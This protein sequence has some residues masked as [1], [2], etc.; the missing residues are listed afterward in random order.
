MKWTWKRI[1]PPVMTLVL[2]IT[3][4]SLTLSAQEEK[5]VD[6]LSFFKLDGATA[7]LKKDAIQFT[8]TKDK[9]T[10]Q[11]DHVLAASGFSLK[12]NAVND[13]EKKLED[14][15]VLLTDS[16]NEDTA[17]RLTFA[18]MNRDSISARCNDDKRTYVTTG[19][20]Y[21]ENDKDFNFQFNESTNSFVDG[22]GNYTI[23]INNSLSGTKFKGFE[24]MG[25]NMTITMQG[26]KG[27]SFV[28][29][30]INSQPLGKDYTTDTVEPVLCVTTEQK[31]MVYG[32]VAVLPKAAAHDVFTDTT[33]LELTVMDP[34]GEVVT[35]EDGTVLEKVDGNQ[36]YRIK[37]NV[38][39]QYRIVYVA[40]DGTNKTRGIGYQIDVQYQGA[41]IV[42]LEEGMQKVASLN[43]EY[44]FPAIKA[45]NNIEGEITTWVN[46]IHPEGYMTCED[47]SF[48]PDTE[49]EYRITFCAMD[50]NGNIG[51]LETSIYAVEGSSK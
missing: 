29:K 26:K 33:S 44:T 21:A 42:S 5:T 51:R 22:A 8:M 45:E 17:V 16:Q 46:V 10:I 24:S 20:M 13:D 34:N 3:G 9:A 4:M 7:K 1:L 50:E 31:K 36:E 49:G 14:I 37:F 41:P 30:E 2:V 25:V 27:A 18:K 40:S 23:K 11:F 39:G 32:C 12:W 35:D 47:E 48:V 6:Q 19:S 43:E 28:L 15:A 38:Y